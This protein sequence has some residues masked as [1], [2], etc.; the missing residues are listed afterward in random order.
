[1]TME[2]LS[3]TW[4]ISF[5]D[6]EGLRRSASLPHIHQRRVFDDGLQALFNIAF[7]NALFCG[8]HYHCLNKYL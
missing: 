8:V 4:Y 7:N 1:M 5:E 6:N 3:V 2:T